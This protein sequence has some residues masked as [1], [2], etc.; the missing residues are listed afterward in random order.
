MRGSSATFRAMFHRA[1]FF[2]LTLLASHVSAATFYVATTGNDTNSGTATNL[3]WRTVQKAAN[4]LTPGDTALVRSGVYSEAVTVNVSGS[5]DNFVTFQNYPG[6]TPIV[7]GSTVP[8][9]E[10]NGG[11]LTIIGRSNVFSSIIVTCGSKHAPRL[12]ELADFRN[13]GS[14]IEGR[15]LPAIDGHGQIV[16]RRGDFENAFAFGPRSGQAGD[17]RDAVGVQ[18]RERRQR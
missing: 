2:S 6:E 11:L 17:L 13:D 14:R 10:G 12:Q 3:A 9:P 18:S 4:T 16:A 8:V 1:I 5:A 15:H 7:D